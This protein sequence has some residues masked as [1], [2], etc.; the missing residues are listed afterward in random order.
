MRDKHDINNKNNNKHNNFNNQNQAKLTESEVKFV[1]NNEV[2]RIATTHNNMPHLVPISYIYENG[3]FYFATDYD[4]K[5]YRNLKKNNRAALVVDVYNSSVNNNRAVMVQGIT[6]LIKSGDEFKRLYKIF[7]KKF[8]WV[9][10]DP[11]KEGEAP[12]VKLKPSKK[13]SWGF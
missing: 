13:V 4:T 7:E 2:C 11:W 6:E 5:K 3:F 10:N 8:E 9:R 1:S 12:F